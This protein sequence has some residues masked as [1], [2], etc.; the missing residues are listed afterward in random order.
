VCASAWLNIHLSLDGF[1]LICCKH[2]T[3]NHKHWL[4][5]FYVYAPCTRVRARMCERGCASVHV[6]QRSL[7]FGRILFTVGA[8]ILQ[9]AINCMVYVLNINAL[10]VHGRVRVNHARMYMFPHFWT[11]SLKIWW[12]HTRGY[13]WIFNVCVNAC[14]NSA[15]KYTF[16]NRDTWSVNVANPVTGN[17]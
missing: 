15:H 6:I 10:H 8:N 3:N 12:G 11:D 5:T 7:I 2:T 9:I 17:D 13:L 14:P 16:E 1:S 4:R